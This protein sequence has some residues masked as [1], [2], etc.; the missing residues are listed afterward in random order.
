MCRSI[1]AIY[2]LFP[3]QISSVLDWMVFD[4]TYELIQF[5]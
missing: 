5:D 4:S 1:N 2:S 3:Q